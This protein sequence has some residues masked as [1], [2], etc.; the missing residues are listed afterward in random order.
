MR[1]PLTLLAVG[2][3]A[4]A[5]P[6]SARA[7]TPATVP[8]GVFGGFVSRFIPLSTLNRMRERPEALSDGLVA[9]APYDSVWGALK[10]SLAA[11]AIPEGFEDP[12]AGEIGNADI[13]AFKRL[14][15][16]ALASLVR[17]GSGPTGPNADSYVVYLSLV[18][19]AQPLPDREVAVLPLLTGHAVDPAGGRSDA[20]NC[21]STGRLEKLIGEGIN[22]R[23]SGK[24]V[25]R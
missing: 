16:Q 6:E 11:L 13:K 14:G 12:R 21:T 5:I 3:I 15:R 19:L 9:T 24:I 17:C 10:R 2:S 25:D 1:V 7:Q 22:G 23:L 20:V 18:V 8:S 4:G